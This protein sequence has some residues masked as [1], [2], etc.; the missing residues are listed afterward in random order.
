ML[1]VFV[2]SPGDVADERRRVDLVVERLNGEFEGRLRIEPIRWETNYYSAHD[3]FQTQ[4]PEA[5]DCD[6]VVAIFRARLGSPLPAGFPRLP[7]G[8]PY[9]SGT[10]YEVLSAID[11]RK[12]GK[13]FPDVYVFRYPIAPT[14]ALDDPN[15]AEIEAEWLRLK[16]FFETWFRNQS[17][18][19]LAAFQSYSSTDDFA[20]KV[21]QCLRQWL[22]RR[23]FLP[24]GLV[25]DRVLHGSP[26]PGLSA[27]EADRGSV[28]FGRDLAIAQ[29][30]ERLREASAGGK[31]LPFLLILGASG[32]GKSSLVRA[33][34]LPRLTLPGTIPEIDLW[35]TAI[36]APGPDPF[37]S[38][39]ECLLTDAALGS[40]LRQGAFSTRELLA[41]QLASDCDTAV[42]P[43]VEALDKAARMRQRDANFDAVRPA[44]LA[45]AIDQAERL[46]VE[47]PAPAAVAFA[48]LL[49]ALVRR[50]IVYAVFVLRSDVYGRFQSLESLI[51][52]REAGVTFDLVPPT[53]AEL[54]EIVTRPVTACQPSLAFEQKDGRSLA[55]TLV[56]D[57][58]GGDVLPLLQMTLSRLYAA[59]GARGDGVLRF[60]DYR[61]MDAAVTETANEALETLDNEAREQLP[62]LVTGLVIDIAADPLTGTLT[63]IIAAL[64]RKNFEAQQPARKVLVEAFVAKRLLTAEGDGVF[65][66]VRP[67]HEA[68][69]RIWPQAVAILAENAGL[70]RVRRTLEPIV[71][72]WSA[73]PPNEKP[74][75]LE[76][77]PALLGGAQQLLA[78]LENDL[79]PEMRNFIAEAAAADAARRDR[80]RR[81]QEDRLR[82]AQDLAAA[83]RRMARRTGAGLAAALVLVALA[84]WQWWIARTQTRIA[85]TQ[86]ERA[87]QAARDDEA[88]RDRALAA[89]SRALA[90]L[91]DQRVNTG[92]V[93]TG[94]LL[95]L[96]AADQHSTPDVEGALINGRLHLRETAILPLPGN[97][98]AAVAFGPNGRLVAAASDEAEI[99]D[100]KTGDRIIVL[101]GHSDSITDAKFSP[102]GKSV[103]TASDDASARI[104]D[105]QTGQT[106]A[107]LNGHGGQVG[108]VEFSYDGGQLLTASQDG[109]ARIWDAKSGKSIALLR[110]H[111]QPINSAVFSPDGKSVLTTSKDGTARVWD[112]KTGEQVAKFTGH[113]G[114]VKHGSFS[115]DGKRIATASLDGTAAVW[116]AATGKLIAMLKGHGDRVFT[117]EFIPNSNKIV[118]AS[119]D[120]TARIWDGSTGATI[121]ILAGH[122]GAVFGARPSP[123]GRH[124]ITA[125]T[126]RSARIWAIDTARVVA[127]LSGHSDWVMKA[128]FAPDGKNVVTAGRDRT[129]RLWTAE[130]VSIATG[131]GTSGK[132]LW[133]AALSPD[134]TRAAAPA[135]ANT[136]GIWDTST[137]ALAA[138][139]RGH[140]SSVNGVAFDPSGRRVV[141]T[142]GDG[143]ARVWNAATGQQLTVLS[144]HKGAVFSAAFSPDGSNIVTGSGDKT[145]R[146]WDAATGRL[147]RPMTGHEGAVTRVA[148]SPDGKRVAS[149]SFDKTVRLWDVETGK[150]V[151]SARGDKWGIAFS[152]DGRRLVVTGIDITVVAL[153]NQDSATTYSG[154]G[155]RTVDVTYS[156][157]GRYLLLSSLDGTARVWNAESGRQVAVLSGS[158][159]GVW[160]IAISA[161]GRRVLTA[162]GVDTLRIWPMGLNAERLSAD[163]KSAIPR[164]LT[165]DER[166]EFNLPGSAPEWCFGLDKWPYNSRAWKL[167]HRH[168]DDADKPPQP[169]APEW[170]V[171][172]Q[173]QGASLLAG[174]PA[175]ALLCFQEAVSLFKRL[176]G[177]DRENPRWKVGLA[178]NLIDTARAMKALGRLTEALSALETASPLVVDWINADP[179]KPERQEELAYVYEHMA[180]VLVK[181]RKRADGIASYRQALAIRQK[182]ADAQPDDPKRQTALAYVKQN[183]AEHLL[184][185][186][187]RTEALGYAR[188]TVVIRRHL[189]DGQPDDA[190]RQE[191]LA[192]ALRVL[193]DVLAA[194]GN[195]SEAQSAYQECISIRQKLAT[196][197]PTNLD[198]QNALAYAREHFA[199]GLLAN[200]QAADAETVYRTAL[201]TR[202]KLAEAKPDDVS[203]QEAVAEDEEQI[204]RALEALG[205]DSES[206]AAYRVSLSIRETLAARVAHEETAAKGKPGTLTADKLGSV[207]WTA[208]LAH[209]FDKAQLASRRAAELA[210]DLIWV[211]TNLAHALMFLNQ[212]DEA[213]TIYFEFRGKIALSNGRTWE[214]A[215]IDDFEIFRKA[216]L[217]NPLMDEIEKAFRPKS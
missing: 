26:F 152:P 109:T 167:W 42:A 96:E 60:I 172:V 136:V 206:V 164:C 99:W 54:E 169:G 162:S 58:R 23:G 175:E 98:I 38:L 129:A 139:L 13:T 197:E 203:R 213:R 5:A 4:I 217:V 28:F 143:T 126:D 25:W 113:S 69:L 105:A 211:K 40:E 41:K 74:R 70:I 127:V 199:A 89:R 106:I 180:D 182:F 156:S 35:R 189:V 34:L 188:D 29:T 115:A 36:M 24:Q 6:V 37:L 148:F 210:P 67:V 157:D 108:S 147:L 49:A 83:Q 141:T 45:L 84:G 33:A 15:R 30:V 86:T 163:L 16:G 195:W 168:K 2:S 155:E 131:S 93:S 50:N 118:T 51:A 134:G 8:D 200:G 87:E 68:L 64:D 159:G 194:D 120:H 150:Q 166:N 205:R 3:T 66:R 21:E 19:F 7:S 73:A 62:A 187:S 142:S 100:P 57:A 214:Q 11:A 92:D 121:A 9:P 27:F 160:T 116:E 174:D 161:D 216:R 170:L 77:S 91:A 39:A 71:R 97:D 128:A 112:A 43:V 47:A 204:A 176:A 17:G 125:S 59:E 212:T 10:A 191:D 192:F 20:T 14:V 72:D 12:A 158:T 79:P 135:D 183:L 18:E 181:S 114:E 88:Q 190:D 101:S 107:V 65:E 44:R 132:Q 138:K 117:A 111:D 53:S 22:R 122:E 1:R 75:H 56:A 184:A 154:L 78:R 196:A 104:W 48:G 80:E 137:G 144:A 209:D 124:I 153:D 133:R 201:A 130:T 193:A 140:T 55:S 63:P 52:L 46:F 215:V 90:A 145:V 119:Y 76:I 171:W 61:G 178:V 151:T 123:D 165:P 94:I 198:R 207:G 177:N 95:A 102:D 186:K 82:A 208:L 185:E 31:R 85:Q 146:I 173:K 149:V 179:S 103:A 110:G 32:S 81:E 202:Q